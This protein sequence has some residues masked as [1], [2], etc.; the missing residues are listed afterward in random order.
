MKTAPARAL[1]A[2]AAGALAL[3]AAVVPAAGATTPTACATGVPLG[4]AQGWTEFVAGSGQRGS[5]SEGSVA[6]GGNLNGMTIGTRLSS[7]KDDPTLVVAGT[8]TGWFN[9]QK[10][11]A[12]VPNRSGGGVN[13]NGGGHYLTTNPIDFPGAFADLRDRSAN[14]A[15]V[16]ANGTADVVN[17]DVTGTS[18][19]GNVLW[20][21][22]S[23]A[24]INVFSVT[25]AQLAGIRAT[26]IDVPAGS[27]ALINVSGTSVTVNGE[28]RYKSGS[29]Y[30]Q[31]DDAPVAD[32]VKRTIW[33]FAAATSVKLNTGSAFGGTIVAPDAAVE[34]VSVG[35]NNGQVIAASFKSNF[36]TH[37]Y[38]FPG[39]GC[40]PGGTTPPGPTSADVA[41]TKTASDA[42]PKGGDAVT[43]TVAVRNNGPDTAKN[44]VVTDAI[45]PGVTFSSASSPCTQS[46]GI[47]TCAIGDL[48]K[49][50]TKTL[51]IK[52]MADPIASVGGPVPH[53]GATH[54]LPVTKVEQQVDLEA[55]DT[56]T[57][58]LSCPAGGV[59][60]DGSIRTDA[61]D[62][63][64]GALTDVRVLSARSTGVST[65]EAVVRN[66]ADGRAQAKGFAVCLPEKTEAADGHAHALKVS[67]PVA[68]TQALAPGHHS[69]TVSCPAG[70]TPIAPGWALHG[71]SAVVTGSEP[72]SGGWRF[73]LAVSEATTAT[74][75]AR[76]LDT[77][78]ATADG[79]THDLELAHVVEHITVPAGQVVEGQ[80]ICADGAKGIVGTW[81]L[82]PGVFSLGNDPRPK[83]RAYKLINTGGAPA[84]ATIDLECIG[85]RTGAERKPGPSPKTV[86][87]IAKAGGETADPDPSNNTA[88]ATIVV[89]PGGAALVGRSAKLIGGKVARTARTAGR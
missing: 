79:H 15:A 70:S 37:Q 11:S 74:L 55:G 80:V 46:A 52:V 71:G 53:P 84:T 33:N 34:A 7:G 26:F 13:F 20:L 9:L 72:V 6:Y 45:P 23:D 85:D 56:K 10:G 54:L 32:A 75:S 78:V 63:G 86:V 61:V 83:T 30:R 87:N 38:L 60:T 18:L 19:G 36:E 88:S 40:V 22:G 57:V 66:D 16:A 67:D 3:L 64:T 31:A 47:V 76:C 43:Y 51:T 68:V 44:V 35:H 14:W 58:A 41:I 48:A 1:A 24:Q 12:Y 49:D 69:V 27:T 39:D 25:P 77:A 21:R 62:Q 17:S 65:W 82:P 73:D 59:L 42:S 29:T 81:S 2:A 50:A 89:G 4:A 28:V 5:E 8:A